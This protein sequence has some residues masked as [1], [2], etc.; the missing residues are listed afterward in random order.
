MKENT[1]PD[2]LNAPL[3]K[4]KAGEFAYVERVFSENKFFS[5]MGLNIQK[6][7]QMLPIYLKNWRMLLSRMHLLF[8]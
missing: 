6:A 4:L 7:L 8:L 3:H 5:F 2:L 1:D